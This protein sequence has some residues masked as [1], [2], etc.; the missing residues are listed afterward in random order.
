MAFIK[1]C[2][3]CLKCTKVPKIRKFGV[4]EYWGVG[5]KHFDAPLGDERTVVAGDVDEP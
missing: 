3:K 2:L 1:K 5:V 4:M